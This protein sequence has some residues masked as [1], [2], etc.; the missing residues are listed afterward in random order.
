M[1]AELGEDMKQAHSPWMTALPKRAFPSWRQP[2]LALLLTD[3]PASSHVSP[4]MFEK[5]CE[6]ALWL[7]FSEDLQGSQLL[8]DCMI[9]APPLLLKGSPRLYIT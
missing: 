6:V 3:A 7:H 9:D 5:A 1:W 4:D 2:S 8:S